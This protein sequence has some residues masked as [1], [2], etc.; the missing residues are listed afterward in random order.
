ML[1]NIK[2]FEGDLQANGLKFG[3]VAA[4]FNDFFVATDSACFFLDVLA[5]Y[6]A[7]FPADCFVSR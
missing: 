1:Q 2:T 4:R 5:I 6:T 7:S 3:L